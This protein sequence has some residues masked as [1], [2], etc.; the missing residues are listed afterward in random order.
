M[1]VDRPNPSLLLNGDHNRAMSDE[2]A[3]DAIPTA[4]GGSGSSGGSGGGGSGGSNLSQPVQL[5]RKPK[6]IKSR[7]RAAAANKRDG[8]EAEAVIKIRIPTT[9]LDALSV[10]L[11]DAL[12]RAWPIMLQVSL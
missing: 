5:Y 8:T 12:N 6:P 4:S 9:L 7:D 11:T 1:T 10:F 2:P 3:F